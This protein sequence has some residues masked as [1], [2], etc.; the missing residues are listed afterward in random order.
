[1]NIIVAS[2]NQ[3]YIVVASTL[4]PQGIPGAD[5]HPYSGTALLDFGATP[6]RDGSFIITDT[7]ITPTDV[8]TVTPLVD[9]EHDKSMDEWE[10]DAFILRGFAGDGQITVYA[11]PNPGPVSGI[12]KINYRVI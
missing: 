2:P 11:T 10:M 6:T 3:E 12:F 8:I 4:G 9:T 1:M 5:Y 7:N